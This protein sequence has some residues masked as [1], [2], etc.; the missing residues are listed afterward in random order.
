ME[1]PNVDIVFEHA[2]NGMSIR[3]WFA[4]MAL[5]GL[6]SPE[7]AIPDMTK[8]AKKIGVGA[9]IFAA[10]MAYGMADAMLAERD[11]GGGE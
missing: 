10:R 1:N 7:N 8:A 2:Q 6:L 4:G 9:F 3:D 11:K 5:Q